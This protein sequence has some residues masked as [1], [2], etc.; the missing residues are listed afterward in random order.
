VCLLYLY[1]SE[2]LSSTNFIAPEPVPDTVFTLTILDTPLKNAWS[3]SRSNDPKLPGNYWVMPHFSSWSWP[4]PFIG[5]L[6]EALY[7]IDVIEEETKWE[8]KIDK[9]VWRGTGH[10]NSVGNIQMRPQLLDATRDKSWADVEVLKWGTN[11]VDAE[12][13]I[14]IEDFCKYKYIIY[15]EG[16]TVGPL[17]SPKYRA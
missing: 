10:F 16:I 2:I 6:D 15:T 4:K 9:A 13:A 3:F 17:Q 14:G 12:N 1:R 7:E 8:D 5:T 11:G